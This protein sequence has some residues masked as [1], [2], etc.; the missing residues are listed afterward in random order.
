MLSP[1]YLDALTGSLTALWRQAEDDM[2]RDAARRFGGLTPAAGGPAERRQAALALRGD[3]AR[4]LA[5]YGGRGDAEMRRLLQ[6]AGRDALAADDAL[7]RAAGLAPTP[8][9][10]SPALLNLLNA[11]HR[12]TQGAWR[13]L[14]ATTADTVTRQFADALDR[15]WMQARS[16]AFGWDT[17]MKNAVDG[18]ARDMKYI[19]YPGGRRDTLEAA[20]RRCALTGA[21]QT[22][23][24]LQLARADEL[25]C[26]FLEVTAHAGARP[27]HAAWQGKVYH[28]GGAVTQDG[29]R[30]EDF[31][32]ATGYGSAEGLCGW[33]CRH[34]FRPFFPGASQRAYT[35]EEL[36]RLADDAEYQQRQQQR[37]LE[38]K[39]RAARRVYEAEDAA[40]LDAT[41]ARARWTQA[42][43]ELEAWKKEAARVGAGGVG[44]SKTGRTVGDAQPFSEFKKEHLATAADQLLPNYTKAQIPPGKLI[45]YALN[46]NHTTGGHDKAVAFER[47]L[48]YT[49]SN[50]AQLEHAVLRELSRWKAVARTPTKYG[51]PFQVSMLLKGPN[52]K[53]AKVKTGWLI[54]DGADFPRLTTI[55][56]DN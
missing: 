16:G 13:R 28:R 7:Y 32:A 51:Q 22:C 37:A 40:G 53:Y 48:G 31:V 23:A 11:G 50:A 49:A 21:N 42:Q 29:V 33:N 27:S 26:A 44:R 45:G 5:Q 2:L 15:A 24:K 34:N 1:A 56:V 20:A 54:D 35:D 12:Q 10:R 3:V 55:Y 52:G 39:A 17:A 9:D 19:T 8:A 43:R 41:A 46:M 4:T 14:T 25:G 38:R 30:Y 6:Q 18:L 47:A 36:A